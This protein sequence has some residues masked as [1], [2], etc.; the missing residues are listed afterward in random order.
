MAVNWGTT[1]Q[2]SARHETLLELPPVMAPGELIHVTDIVTENYFGEN[3][4]WGTG[5]AG[6]VMIVNADGHAVDFV[7]WGYDEAHIA[8]LNVNVNGFDMLGERAGWNGPG[9][10]SSSIQ[11]T[12]QRTGDLDRSDASDFVHVA[13]WDNRGVQNP[14]LTLPVGR[15]TIPGIGF[16]PPPPAF[17]GT[18][19]KRSP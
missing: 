3:I 10:P 4:F 8:E 15:E 12:M 1:G 17:G 13:T 5:G 2:I 11:T 16:S 18:N 6:W 14:A 9:V 19:R 7:P